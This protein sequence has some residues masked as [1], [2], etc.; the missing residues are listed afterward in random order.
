P[1]GNG[2]WIW[3]LEDTRRVLYRLPE[4]IKAIALAHPILVV[5]G[6]KD[7]DRLR[8]IGLAATCNSGGANKWRGEYNEVFRGADVV[9]VPDDDEPGWKHVSDVGAHLH[10]IAARIRVLM[11]NAKDASAWI[12]AGGTRD[13]LD[14]LIEL[15]PDWVA[16]TVDKEDKTNKAK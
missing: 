14:Q 10:G 2:G 5:E 12:E 4:L 3:K 7:V 15:A 16:P 13:Q 11:L 1:D 8:A 6:E 9:L